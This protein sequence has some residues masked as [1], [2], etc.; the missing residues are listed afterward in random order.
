MAARKPFSASDVL[1]TASPRKYLANRFNVLREP[2]PAPDPD[3]RS[4]SGSVSQKRKNSD[5]GNVP[6]YSAVLSSGLAA[7]APTVVILSEEKV[8]ELT[9]VKS[10]CEKVSSD[11]A[12]SD[13]DPRVLTIL[14][15]INDAV[16][17]LCNVVSTPSANQS[18]IPTQTAPPSSS[19]MV[20]LGAISKRP[21]T[22]GVTVV[23]PPSGTGDVRVVNSVESSNTVPPE[24]QRFRDAVRDAEKSTLIFNLDMGRVPIM[25]TESMS[26]RATLAL[27][28]MA[29]KVENS[30]SE[31]PSQD[32]IAIIDDVLSV[33]T[34]M[35]FFGSTTKS[36][37]NPR[38]P[39]KSSFCTVPV[40]YEFSDKDTR[41]KAENVLRTT[42]NISYTTPYPPILRECI[43]RTIDQVKK[44]NP[45]TVV[46]VNIDLQNHVLKVAR[47]PKSEDKGPWEYAREGIP[48]PKEAL[49]VRSR[50]IPDT[51]TL[52]T[53]SFDNS[54]RA[55]DIESETRIDEA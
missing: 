1:R 14:G 42:C 52:N 13:A 39:L 35:K 4:R 7:P 8:V 53:V 12:G 33:S 45:N 2:S 43:K 29:A 20:S 55:S 40:K 9:M 24:I 16:L 50:K 49:D 5:D 11:I 27:T 38:D 22:A 15:S 37:S 17:K 21:R 32:S 46:K 44:S 36:Y 3:N 6:S 10:I 30:K 54:V 47:R 26:R 28:K 25:N 48:I 23:T 51:L 19:G 31:V 18:V 34:G 41:I